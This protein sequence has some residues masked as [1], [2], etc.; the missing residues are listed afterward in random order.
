MIHHLARSLIQLSQAEAFQNLAYFLVVP[1]RALSQSD[2]D[3]IRHDFV[4]PNPLGFGLR[5]LLSLFG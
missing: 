3:L 4:S 1:N 5:R 2:F